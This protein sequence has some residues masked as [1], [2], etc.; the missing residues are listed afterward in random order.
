MFI[1]Y[2]RNVE[3]IFLN[4]KH[5]VSF[6]CVKAVS[7]S[8]TAYTT[9]SAF[10]L[11]SPKSFPHSL[12]CPA[13]CEEPAWAQPGWQGQ[14]T[15]T[16]VCGAFL[17]PMILFLQ[18]V[19]VQGRNPLQLHASHLSNA[20]GKG[21][22]KMQGSSALLFISPSSTLVFLSVKWQKSGRSFL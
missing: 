19:W 5:E 2:G 10:S 16:S 7:S 3:S 20:S 8:L 6:A 14:P 9:T 21:F 12:P 1:C 4:S 22:G 11:S 15:V 13:A 17:W 18:T